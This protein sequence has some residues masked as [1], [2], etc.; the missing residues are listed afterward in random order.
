MLQKLQKADKHL[1]EIAS[2]R[3]VGSY[4]GPEQR[5]N[6][7][8]EQFLHDLDIVCCQV[9]DGFMVGLLR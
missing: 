8:S 4:T 2:K 7:E 6:S 1:G 5:S 9:G 3:M